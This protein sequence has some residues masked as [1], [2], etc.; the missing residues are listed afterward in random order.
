MSNRFYCESCRMKRGTP[1]APDCKANTKWVII[2]GTLASGIE[3]V[4][5]MFDTYDEASRWADQF[6]NVDY[7]VEEVFPI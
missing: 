5:G 4:V 6:K 3:E 2:Y 7:L 1:H